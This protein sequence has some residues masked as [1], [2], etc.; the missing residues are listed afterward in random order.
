MTA[1]AHLRRNRRCARRSATLPWPLALAVAAATAELAGRWLAP[2]SGIIEP[3]PVAL[4]EHFDRDD[5]DRAG[6]SAVR[7]GL[8][9]AVAR[10][11]LGTPAAGWPEPLA[12]AASGGALAGALAVAPLP[13]AAIAHGRARGAGLATQS[14]RAWLGDVGKGTA[15]SA[16]LSGAVAPALGALRRRQPRWWWLGASVG[17]VAADAVFTFL[18]PIALDPLFNRFT[19]LPAGATRDAVMALAREAQVTVGEV[20]EVDA[21]RRTTAAN[22]YV[23]GL[24][25][26][27]R[28]V[29]FDT[30]LATFSEP[31]ARLV[32]AHELA[33]VRH[34]DVAHGL[35]Y[36]SLVAPASA[37]AVASV[38][39][40]LAAD[41]RSGETDGALAGAEL[42]AL[43]AAA[44]LVSALTAISARR[45]S[46]RIEA[47]AD[48]FSLRLTDAPEPFVSFE[49]RI[50]LQN[51]ADPA[52]PRW[53]V[54]L[55]G[56]HPPA[57]ERI[58]IARAYARGA[59]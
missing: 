23:T 31:E 55:L 16:T 32:V 39:Q 42:A 2:R 40:A 17:A 54:L 52:P 49:R 48:S 29:L 13:L 10:R 8:L 56:S 3:D 33:H 34:R 18:A 4:E 19:V 20:Y 14:W 27:K 21:S 38:A 24:G 11:R 22:A 50:V 5:V 58:G 25:A 15:I 59:R 57:L 35:L 41:R 30:L 26:T 45:L 36:L 7:L 9:V 44:G 6:S 47:R 12:G 51:L 1:W 53:L 28:V 43:G 46:R 37:H